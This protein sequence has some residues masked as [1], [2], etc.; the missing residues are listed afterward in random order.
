MIQNLSIHLKEQGSLLSSQK[1]LY[2]RGSAEGVDDLCD[3]N[4]GEEENI[5]FAENNDLSADYQL[6]IALNNL[7]EI[8]Q[9]VQSTVSF[10]TWKYHLNSILIFFFF[11][12]IA[13]EVR[14]M[15]G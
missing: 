7:N 13:T 14:K 2:D 12:R 10:L 8:Y 6:N 4:S 11:S 1:S 9:A 15:K 5:S 3:D